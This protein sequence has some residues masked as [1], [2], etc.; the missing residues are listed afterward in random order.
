MSGHEPNDC[1]D[2]HGNT[3]IDNLD[4]PEQKKNAIVKNSYVF[5]LSVDISNGRV[6]MPIRNNS[7]HPIGRMGK[8][9]HELRGELA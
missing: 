6:S 8:I 2:M 9:I 5:R 7:P 1:G 4:W 3:E